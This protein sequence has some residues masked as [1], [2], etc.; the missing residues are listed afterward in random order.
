MFMEHGQHLIFCSLG[1]LNSDLKKLNTWK[2]SSTLRGFYKQKDALSVLSVYSHMVLERN[3]FTHIA[4]QQANSIL[5]QCLLGEM[6]AVE[7]VKCGF[8]RKLPLLWH[9]NVVDEN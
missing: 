9:A 8:W 7:I 5:Q 4:R 3:T 1:H 2:T 6:I